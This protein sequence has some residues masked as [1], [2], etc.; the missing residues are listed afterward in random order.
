[1]FSEIYY[2]GWTATVDGQPVEV[3][4]VDYVLRAIRVEAGKHEIDLA[5]YPK[6]I[7]VTETIAY[8]TGGLLVLAILVL[9]YMRR[10]KHGVSDEG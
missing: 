9:L 8:I 10:R 2:P 4:R 1:M 3:G 7:L 6:S 5:F